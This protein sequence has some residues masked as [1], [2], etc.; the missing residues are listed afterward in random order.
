MRRRYLAVVPMWVLA[1]GLGCVDEQGSVFIDYILKIETGPCTVT[2]ASP[3]LFQGSLDIGGLPDE[4]K[5]SNGALRVT[6]NLPAT[7]TT[8]SISEQRTKSPNYPN[9]GPVDSNVIVFHDVEVYFTDSRG[10][11][12]DI[13][14]IT[15]DKPRRT[16]VGGSVYNTNTQLGEKSV[17]LAPLVTEEEAVEL[18][19]LNNPDLAG[20]EELAAL[21]NDPTN[22]FRINAHARVLGRTTGGAEVVSAEF[23]YPID[24]CQRCL[25]K[26]GVPP[27]QTDCPP[28]TTLQF[29]QVCTPGQDE[30]TSACVVPA[31]GTP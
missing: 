2:E 17:V 26:V 15:A 8:S 21:A 25:A 13:L 9:Y 23:S 28:G 22:R 14:G 10:E 6:T 3:Q 5:G 11:P 18:Q 30:F 16:P 12:I 20:R 24:L 1:L 4:A 29:G 7:V 31:G 19:L 27:G